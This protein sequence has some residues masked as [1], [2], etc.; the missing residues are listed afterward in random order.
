MSLFSRFFDCKRGSFAIMASLLTVPLAVGAGASVDYSRLVNVRSRLQSAA[1]ATA[2]AMAKE[3][4]KLTDAE[5]QTKGAAYFDALYASQAGGLPFNRTLL[6]IT[7][8]AKVV[9]VSVSGAVP[10]TL[11]KLAGINENEITAG[12]QSAWGT[13]K[14]EVALVLDNTGSMASSG[15]LTE[16]KKAAKNLVTTLE[17]VATEPGAVKISLVPFATQVRLDTGLKNAAWLDFASTGTNK[18]TWTGCVKDRTQPADVTDGGP[19]LYPAVN[20]AATTLA[21]VRA[22]STDFTGL[23][24]A[25]DGMN[26]NGNTNITIGLAWGLT[27]LSPAD[28]MTGGADFGTDGVEKFVIMLTDGDNTQN[29]WSSSKYAIDLRTTAACT[30]IKSPARKVSLYTIRVIDGE[31]NLLRNCATS[32]SM[33]FDVKSATELDAVFRKIADEIASIRLTV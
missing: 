21:P 29:A 10:T 8:S 6:T 32:P 26:A 11:M 19:A 12:S 31:A 30:E 18:A 7:R 23:R 1:D 5:L 15:K 33:F 17:K 27:T 13:R 3:A 14:I 20:C 25:I 22:L 4:G 2:L 9:Q 24:T 16:M 28:P